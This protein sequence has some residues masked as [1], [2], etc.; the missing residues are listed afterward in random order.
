MAL[1]LAGSLWPFWLM[2]GYLSEGRRWLEEALAL[3]GGRELRTEA[4]NAAGHLA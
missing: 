2:R 3:D 1:R 4:L